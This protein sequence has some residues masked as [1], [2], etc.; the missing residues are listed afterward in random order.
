[1]FHSRKLYTGA[2]K[3]VTE[4]VKGKPLI[5]EP[6]DFPF[7]N[8]D[9]R[10]ATADEL[11][12]MVKLQEL[13]DLDKIATT[14]RE[15]IDL[16]VAAGRRAGA[17]SNSPANPECTHAKIRTRRSARELDLAPTRY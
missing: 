8:I 3:P 1:V 10:K 13:D 17:T 11:R 4:F 12:Y 14:A 2:T 15:L 9:P 6:T 16:G 5:H 7:E